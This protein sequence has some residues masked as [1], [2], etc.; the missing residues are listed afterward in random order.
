MQL[1]TAFAISLPHVWSFSG[2]HPK[3]SCLG[4]VDEIFQIKNETY[5]VSFNAPR[6]T[7]A[8]DK[9]E[10]SLRPWIYWLVILVD[11]FTVLTNCDNSLNVLK[12]FCFCS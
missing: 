9:A 8:T 5:S 11:I 1:K 4:P 12:N 3:S 10:T 2:N 7:T 6:F